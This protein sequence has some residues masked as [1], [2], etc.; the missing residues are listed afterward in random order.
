M[1]KSLPGP[2][3]FI[4]NANNNIPKMFKNKMKYYLKYALIRAQD[5]NKPPLL[6]V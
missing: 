5:K 6:M 2:Y 3:T 1:K 4:L